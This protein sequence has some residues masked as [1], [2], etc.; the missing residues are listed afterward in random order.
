M[1][2]KAPVSLIGRLISLPYCRPDTLLG[3]SLAKEVK[4]FGVKVV[5]VEPGAFRT[6]F[7]NQ[8]SMMLPEGWT[9]AD[10]AYSK[11]NA[12][13][14][15]V[16]YMKS[17]SEKQPGNP[18]EAAKIMWDVVTENGVGTN[19]AKARRDGKVFRVLLGSD[20]LG[21]MDQHLAEREE[22]RRIFA[23]VAPLTDFKE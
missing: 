12:A 2:W 19:L 16:E 6:R 22:T 3:E 13:T 11:D 1:R 4:D 23:D 5:V 15:T 10:S 14:K 20:A 18:V 7:L 21:R 9:Q 8:A 17:A